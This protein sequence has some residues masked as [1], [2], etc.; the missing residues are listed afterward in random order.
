MVIRRALPSLTPDQA[1]AVE[2]IAETK[3]YSYG[4]VIISQGD[5]PDSLFIMISGMGRV[6]L[7]RGSTLDAEFTGPLGPGELFGELNFIDGHPASATV[8]AD[9]DTE[10]IHIG[11]DALR[12]LM[13][14][15]PVLA[16]NIYKDLLLAVTGRLRRTNL[17]VITQ[18]DLE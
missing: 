16:A 6:T 2:A 18:T 13:L 17:R 4:D 10:I 15:E 1:D 5:H 11:G 7:H 12:D 9:G 8:T 3:S 14:N